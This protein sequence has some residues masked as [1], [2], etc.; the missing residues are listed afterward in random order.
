MP[1][2]RP[3]FPSSH[4][5]EEPTSALDTLT[6]SIV[7]ERLRVSGA[8]RMTVMVTASPTLL[9]VCDR[10]V[11]VAGGEAVAA[12]THDGLLGDNRYRKVTVPSLGMGGEQR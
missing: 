7:A 9:A 2:G 6:E 5:L 1:R 12:G 8:E 11:F 4:H 10:V 3:R